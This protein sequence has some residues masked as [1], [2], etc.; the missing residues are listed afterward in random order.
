MTRESIMLSYP[1]G[2][3]AR[4]FSDSTSDKITVFPSGIST[5]K[6]PPAKTATNPRKIK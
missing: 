1:S 5:E 2:I 6:Q 3:S 4:T